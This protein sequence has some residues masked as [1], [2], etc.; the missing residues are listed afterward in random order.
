[1]NKPSQPQDCSHSAKPEEL[2]N[3]RNFAVQNMSHI[4]PSSDNGQGCTN[5]DKSTCDAHANVSEAKDDGRSDNG[6]GCTDGD[7]SHVTATSDTHA[8]VSEA[9]DVGRLGG[10]YTQTLIEEE[11]KHPG[12]VD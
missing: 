1:M 4:P 11:S 6:Q 2:S 12:Y 7:K 5:G 9:K 10:I 3:G 8:N